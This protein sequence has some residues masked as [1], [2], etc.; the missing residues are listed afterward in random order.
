MGKLI[1]QIAM[2]GAAACLTGCGGGG[3]GGPTADVTG[4]VLLVATG[5][6]PAVATTV[7]VGGISSPTGTDGVFVLRRV[8]ATAARI[9][10]VSQGAATLTQPLPGLTAGR[11]NDVGDIFVA[12]DAYTAVASGIVVRSDTGAPVAGAT[13]RISGQVAVTTATGQFRITGLPDAL[14]RHGVQAGLV[15][16]TGLEDKPLHFDPELAPSPPDNDLGDIVMS[17]PVGGVPGGPGTIIG[18]ITLQ[19]LTDHSGAIVTLVERTGDMVVEQGTTGPDGR[20]GFWVVP[21]AYRVQVRA[22]GFQPAAAEVDLVRP[23]EPRTVNLT[24]VR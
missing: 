21:G 22:A 6:P 14:G 15:R 20:Y 8:P 12:D 24:L 5:Q 23:D 18:T 10:V 7:T 13:V 4:R 1:A 2:L 11:L 17:L 9:R 3:G 16:A 19:G